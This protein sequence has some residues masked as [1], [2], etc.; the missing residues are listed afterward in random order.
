MSSFA[1]LLLVD[2][3]RGSKPKPLMVATDASE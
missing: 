2:L 1:E 3:A